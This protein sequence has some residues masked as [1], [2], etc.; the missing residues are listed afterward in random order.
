MSIHFEH[1]DSCYMR[2]ILKKSLEDLIAF[3]GDVQETFQRTFSIQVKSHTGHLIDVD[4]LPGGSEIDVTN[5]NRQFFV[6][7]YVDYF[8][9]V[10][11]EKQFEAMLKG[12]N[13]VMESG[14]IKVGMT[15]LFEIDSRYSDDTDMSEKYSCLDLKNFKSC[16]VDLNHL[17]LRSWKRRQSTMDIL[18]RAKSFSEFS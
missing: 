15:F 8:F 14:F 16:F 10:S 12:F 2:Q 6:N 3:K 7:A 17:T 1:Q 11:C 4:L 18:R 9:N 13:S 5:E